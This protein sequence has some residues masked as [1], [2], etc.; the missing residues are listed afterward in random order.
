MAMGWNVRRALLAALLLT[1]AGISW[2]LLKTITVQR[3][4]MMTIDSQDPDY[5]IED[6][7]AT[8]MDAQGQRK[9]TLTAE[10]MQHYPHNDTARLT[11]PHLVQYSPG[12]A[13]VHTWADFARLDNATKEVIMTGNVKIIRENNSSGQRTE[14]IT[15]M[16][17][18]LLD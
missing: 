10:R 18:V 8:V 2:W 5:Y 16:A 9:Y 11:K 3:P 14:M 6:F 13:P 12:R 15:T 4:M 17:R 7:R 1:A